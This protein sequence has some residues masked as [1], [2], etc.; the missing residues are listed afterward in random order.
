MKQTED[1]VIEKADQAMY[2]DKKKRKK[3]DTAWK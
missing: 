3:E 1:D 2:I